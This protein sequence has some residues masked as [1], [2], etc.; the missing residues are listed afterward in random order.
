MGK[1]SKRPSRIA[2]KGV[3]QRGRELRDVDDL[4]PFTRGLQ[5]GDCNHQEILDHFGEPREL[6]SG[7]DRCFPK[8]IGFAT[9]HDFNQ[10]N[11]CEHKKIHVWLPL[12]EKH[13]REL[14]RIVRLLFIMQHQDESLD[15][16]HCVFG[17]LHF[18]IV[19][20]DRISIEVLHLPRAS[21]QCARATSLREFALAA[22]A[23]VRPGAFEENYSE[24]L[25]E[26]EF[27]IMPAEDNPFLLWCQQ[28][29]HPLL[30][31]EGFHQWV[32]D[33]RENCDEHL[34]GVDAERACRLRT[35]AAEEQHR[36]TPNGHPSFPPGCD[37]EN[38]TGT[39]A[40]PGQKTPTTKE[41]TTL[42]DH[43]GR[44]PPSHQG[45]ALLLS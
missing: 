33:C 44:I 12:L 28:H 34:V 41:S 19:T 25:S 8:G 43:D 22:A 4:A 37:V 23:S 6:N 3:G 40:I 26:G 7:E 13:L 29:H 2:S 39:D 10:E 35:F 45:I 17:C 31:P 5:V 21:L 32:L 11:S 30:C 15:L 24:R 18:I 16:V 14:P 20:C 9:S 27:K 1:A 36:S 42:F 38:Y